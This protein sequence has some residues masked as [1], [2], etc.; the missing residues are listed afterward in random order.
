MHQLYEIDTWLL[1]LLNSKGNMWLDHFWFAFT[2]RIMWF[3]FGIMVVAMLWRTCDGGWKC[4]AT[5]LLAVAM[6]MVVLDQTSSGLLKPLV[7]RLR[8]SH[9]P[10]VEN[11]LHYVDG[12]R[13]GR[14]GFPSGHATTSAGI[15]TWLWLTYRDPFARICFALFA[16]A[17]GY[18]RIY[19]GVHWPSDV[20]AGFALGVSMAVGCHRLVGLRV[21]VQTDRRPTLLLLMFGLTLIAIL[22]QIP[23]FPIQ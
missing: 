3:P 13:G 18:S 21:S 5:L 4:K 23:V 11:L 12:Y 7:G 14:L 20:L 19:L 9:T 6:L 8:P 22:C 15:A 2:N 16:L 1:M 17:M 10:C